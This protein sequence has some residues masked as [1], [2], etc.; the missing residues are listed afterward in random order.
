MPRQTNRIIYDEQATQKALQLWQDITRQR[1][2]SVSEEQQ[3]ELSLLFGAS[4]YF[5]RFVCFLGEEVLSVLHLANQ[6]DAGQ[7]D[8][9][10]AGFLA[11]LNI[12][13]DDTAM[14]DAGI[15]AENLTTLRIAKN[16]AMLFVLLLYL[17]GEYDI[18]KM[19]FMLTRIATQ[20]LQGDDTVVW[21]GD[22]C[23]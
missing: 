7:L 12:A 13:T 15:V 16:K 19:E 23:G 22:R 17:K 21:S 8:S 20:V 14:A 10:F 4:W 2:F 6:S 1:K 9:V 11:T 3:Q 5:F 18:E